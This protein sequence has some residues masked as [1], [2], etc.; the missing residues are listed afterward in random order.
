MRF[1]TGFFVLAAISVVQQIAFG[2]PTFGILGSHGIEGAIH[3]ILGG[4]FG[5]HETLQ[6]GSFHIGGGLDILGSVIW[7]VVGKCDV[8]V[9]TCT[10]VI[11]SLNTIQLGGDLIKPC[12]A[13]CTK[14]GISFE[15]LIRICAT[16]VVGIKPSHPLHGIMTQISIIKQSQI[17][18]LTLPPR[19]TQGTIILPSVVLQTISVTTITSISVQIGIQVSTVQNII[20]ACSQISVKG[21]SQVDIAVI[22]VIALQMN[23]SV[24][25]AIQVA[26][27]VLPCFQ[28][29]S[30]IFIVFES[31]SKIQV[32]GAAVPIPTIA[33]STPPALPPS[34][35]TTIEVNEQIL[36]IITQA[37]TA[38]ICSKFSITTAVFQKIVIALSQ[39]NIHSNILIQIQDISTRN[40]GFKIEWIVEIAGK[41][42]PLCPTGGSLHSV[43]Q[44]IV[45][46]INS[47]TVGTTTT[48]I[49][50]TLTPVIGSA[51]IQSPGSIEPF[52]TATTEPTKYYTFVKTDVEHPVTAITTIVDSIL[53]PTAAVSVPSVI[54][55]S[56]SGSI[57]SRVSSTGPAAIETRNVNLQVSS[58]ESCN[59]LVA[60]ISFL[61]IM[62]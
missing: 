7:T 57:R 61:V 39:I 43:F 10:E 32:D 15:T 26:G 46:T 1:N 48:Y 52:T 16:A 23:V 3:G 49:S 33:V 12:T 55:G 21:S 8:T 13:I 20:V 11:E 53:L 37:V 28:V 41:L 42:K 34:K 31:I 30:P 29:G 56:A 60:L 47:P 22:K 14:F 40:E 4:L 59:I 54:L 6:D 44:A 58:G 62:S 45:T 5:K 18:I 51:T 25:V 9:S 50:P 19:P 27:M 2:V 38:E 35:P 24:K 36:Q 17:P